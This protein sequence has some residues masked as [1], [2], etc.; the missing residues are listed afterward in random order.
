MIKGKGA[1]SVNGVYYGTEK[2]TQIINSTEPLLL[3]QE[4]NSTNRH[5]KI[6]HTEAPVQVR[7]IIS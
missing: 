5:Y 1:Y 6:F 4:C 3:P 7:I 2:G